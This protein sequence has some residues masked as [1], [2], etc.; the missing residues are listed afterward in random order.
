M[1]IK[2]S[3]RMSGTVRTRK[4]IVRIFEPL[5]GETPSIYELGIPVV[6]TGD[7]WHV[8][9]SQKVPLNTE[10]DNV[11]PAFLREVR[12]LVMNAM[13]E[14][15]VPEDATQTWAREALADP[16]VSDNAVEHTMTLLYGPK[17][18]AYDPSDVEA[19]KRAVSEGFTLVYGSSMSKDQWANVRRAEA[20]RPA[21]QVTPGHY[22][23]SG[24]DGIPPIDPEKW[25]QAMRRLAVYTMDV[26]LELLGF[27]PHVTFYNNITLQFAGVWNNRTI[28]F[29]MGKLGKKWVENPDQE[30]IDAL[31]LHEFAHEKISDHLSYQFP[32]EVA[33]LGARLRTVKARL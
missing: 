1:A 31:L 18:V 2:W 15:L 23:L 4:T 29:N 5:P 11:R 27:R 14:Q 22:V 9:I 20:V 24:P 7:R 17:R 21:G 32:D 19:N 6:E 8:D 16:D 10:R 28:G 3:E 30:L 13:F 33:R 25:T 26:G 12:T